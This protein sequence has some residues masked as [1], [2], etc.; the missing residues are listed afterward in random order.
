MTLLHVRVAIC[1]V[2]IFVFVAAPTLLAGSN[3]AAKCEIN[4][5]KNLMFEFVTI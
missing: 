4:G 2:S 5:V 1:F 3:I